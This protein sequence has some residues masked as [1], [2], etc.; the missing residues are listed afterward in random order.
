MTAIKNRD[1][2]SDNCRMVL[3]A[4]KNM[5][6]AKLMDGTT[7]DAL[8]HFAY[9]ECALGNESN[10]LRGVLNALDVF[11]LT[12]TSQF[13]SSMLSDVDVI[14]AHKRTL[15]LQYSKEICTGIRIAL[16]GGNKYV[17]Q[18]YLLNAQSFA[19]QIESLNKKTATREGLVEA[20]SLIRALCE[21][22]DHVAK[23]Q[24]LFMPGKLQEAW[25]KYVIAIED[26]LY[27]TTDPA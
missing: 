8:N 9:S 22:R 19:T 12:N 7:I 23:N 24:Q 13:Q 14:E 11:L 20:A 16:R 25:T 5:N 26:A 1:T 15:L 2:I 4:L 21:I 10:L 27:T 6:A 3:I 18:S 17:I